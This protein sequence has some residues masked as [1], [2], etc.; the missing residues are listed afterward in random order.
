MILGCCFFPNLPLSFH[1]NRLA[2]FLFFFPPLFF[3]Y[4]ND[5]VFT[6][7]ITFSFHS[8]RLVAPASQRCDGVQNRGWKRAQV[9]AQRH[10]VKDPFQSQALFA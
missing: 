2:S 4:N 6:N 3:L 7:T 5:L 1:L 9:D 10:R 8:I